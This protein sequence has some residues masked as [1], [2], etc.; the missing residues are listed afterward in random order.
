VQHFY[1]TLGINRAIKTR[2]KE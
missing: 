1:K 2:S